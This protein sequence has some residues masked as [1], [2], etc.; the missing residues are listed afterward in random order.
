MMETRKN[1]QDFSI[2]DV[3]TDNK[4]FILL[5]NMNET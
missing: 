1:H 3:L 4:M 5:S 2:F